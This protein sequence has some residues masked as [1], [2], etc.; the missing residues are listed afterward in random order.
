MCDFFHKLV[1]A[2]THEMDLMSEFR[3]NSNIL[4]FEDYMVI[5]KTN[6]FGWDIL[7]RMELLPSLADQ[8]EEAPLSTVE[9]V[10]LG[11]HISRA[12]ELCAQNNSIH[13]DIRP[14]TI[15]VS[16]RGGYKLGDFGIARR[17]EHTMSGL[18][19]ESMYAYMAPDI[20]KGEP[21]TPSADTYSLGILMYSLL[22]R[23]RTPFLPDFP[24]SIKSGIRAEALKK[25]FS[26]EPVPALKN[27]SPELNELVLKACAYDRDERFA[28][29]ADMCAALETVAE[30][31]SY[32]PAEVNIPLT[33]P[34]YT[35]KPSQ[36]VTPEAS[37][38]YANAPASASAMG[39]VKKGFLIAGLCSFIAATVF[40]I[41]YFIPLLTGSTDLSLA[42]PALLAEHESPLLTSENPDS[43]DYPA[44]SS[45]SPPSDPLN[46]DF[47]G[48]RIT[49]EKLVTMVADNT[50]P[51]NV[52]S[53]DLSHN[54]IS[55]LAPLQTLT[56]LEILNLNYNKIRNLAP[57]KSLTGL[58]VLYL[59]ANLIENPGLRNLESLTRLTTLSMSGNEKISNLSP[60][61]K[62]TGLTALYLNGNT[63]D[64][65]PS[66]NK[67]T[68]LQT[69]S[70]NNN[71]LKNIDTLRLFTELTTLELDNNAVTNLNPLK[72]LADLKFL[73]IRNNPSL[74]PAMINS[75]RDAIPDC[76]IILF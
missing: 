38:A 21:S 2:I 56:E 59:D 1:E 60:L 18:S 33:A 30:A 51:H 13:R 16:P 22:N 68:K 7:I 67:L 48:Q 57:L 71:R 63:I 25:R 72:S 26:G 17:I 55:D 12:L 23:N 34:A 27:V 70:L 44:G 19:N 9:I 47:S 3:G 43:K 11:I 41:I 20:F 49:D 6:A 54:Q 4:R 73:S 58:T 65:L 36:P 14:D 46:F 66:I 52:K 75:L 24:Q 32:V 69:L 29:P 64:S 74:R 42:G 37:I 39:K 10:K 35:E 50:I 28:T 62:L 40:A 76:E 8:I 45:K 15:F 31:M 53:L 61:N 5:E